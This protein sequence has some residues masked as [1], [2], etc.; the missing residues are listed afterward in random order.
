MTRA[1]SRMQDWL[2]QA[3]AEELAEVTADFYPHIARDI[4]ASSLARY[5]D[6]ELW[7]RTPQVSRIGF[8]RLAE[9]LRSGG[10]ISRMP[11]YEDCVDESLC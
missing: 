2:A 5:R 4:L 3:S 1:I 11:K 10:F 6:A 8:S 9:S 7:P